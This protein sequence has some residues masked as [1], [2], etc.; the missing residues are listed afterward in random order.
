MQK[1]IIGF[2]T[3]YLTGWGWRVKCHL[4]DIKGRGKN[5]RILNILPNGVTHLTISLIDIINPIKPCTKNKHNTSKLRVKAKVTSDK[6]HLKSL[7]I[8]NL[9][10]TLS[11]EKFLN[12][13]LTSVNTDISGKKWVFCNPRFV[14]KRTKKHSAFFLAWSKILPTAS[15]GAVRTEWK[16]YGLNI[17]FINLIFSTTTILRVKLYYMCKNVHFTAPSWS[18]ILHT[19]F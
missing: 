16:R 9:G 4:F 13:K 15:L 6:W 18:T 19:F 10:V 3:P 17:R 7:I 5:W 12:S 2:W 8:N 1:K 11:L 14:F